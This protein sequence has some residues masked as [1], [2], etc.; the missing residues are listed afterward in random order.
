MRTAKDIVEDRY[1]YNKHVLDH[2]IKAMSEAKKGSPEEKYWQNLLQ[3]QRVLCDELAY[4]LD[5]F[6]E[7]EYGL[8]YGEAVHEI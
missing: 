4:I 7:M 8:L 5:L 6:K 2:V 3:T 1:N